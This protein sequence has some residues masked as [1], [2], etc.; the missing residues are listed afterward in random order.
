VTIQQLILFVSLFIAF[1]L[2]PELLRTRKF[3]L[4]D[5]GERRTESNIRVLNF[6][7]RCRYNSEVQTE[8]G[9]DVARGLDAEKLRQHAQW[10]HFR[11]KFVI[12]YI[13]LGAQSRTCET[14]NMDG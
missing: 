4:E 8:V 13:L 1:T 11:G 10:E 12:L 2:P 3:T 6:E 7:R 9:H 5:T 14:P